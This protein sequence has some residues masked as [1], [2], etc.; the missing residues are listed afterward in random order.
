MRPGANF[1]RPDY[2]LLTTGYEFPYH[3]FVL[4][5]F[6]SYVRHHAL[7]RPGDRVGV[8]VSGGADSVALLR[9]LLEARPELGIVLSVVHFNHQIRG[10]DADADEQ[11]VREL[12]R[13]LDLEFHCGSGDTPAYARE[14]KLSL[15]AAGRKLRY[16]F[17]D[18]LTTDSTV[19]RVATAHT[20]DDQAETVLMRF[21]RGSGTKG[22]AGIYPGIGGW[23]TPGS[24]D[25][26]PEI[27]PAPRIVRPLLYVSR[28]ELREY[29]KQLGQIWHED[30]SNAD[31]DFARNRLRHEIMPVLRQLNPA[32]DEILSQTAEIARGEEEFWAGK[33]HC[34]LPKLLPAGNRQSAIQLAVLL[35][36]PLA[37]QRR[38][39]RALAEQHGLRL[40][41]L[42][43]E[44][45]LSL[46]GARSPSPGAPSRPV[47][48]PMR[49][50][51][52][53]VEL[54][55]GWEAVRSGQGLWFRRGCQTQQEQSEYDL[56]L[57]VPGEVEVAGRKLCAAIVTGE[58]LAHAGEG[59]RASRVLL[60]PALAH[61]GL[62][63]R[64]WHAGDRYWPAHTRQPKKVKE[65][66]QAHHIQ[67]EQKPF[68][69][70]VVSGDEIV[71]VPGFDA[72]QRFLLGNGDSAALLLEE[73]PL[74][75]TGGNEQ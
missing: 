44:Q 51:S 35:A 65:L 23:F 28:D 57:A 41:F 73:V 62:R 17:F 3:N 7:M 10:A 42:H 1:G 24:G 38:L 20:R 37:L 21:L 69:P 27:P 13:G 31:V 8:A 34:L 5:R 55:H 32:L 29:L 43:V 33:V 26:K 18:R 71:W 49:W 59:A 16:A 75:Q 40:E 68:W 25:E 74:G 9:L 66:L 53:Q 60:D 72:P 54:P 56:S 63:V 39:I 46:L 15:E 52:A 12:A 36:Q 50:S 64:N 19:H 61:R 45:L 70:V 22:L 2:Q 11:F 30:A 47:V 14:H 67:R 58:D 6:L 48:G 4:D